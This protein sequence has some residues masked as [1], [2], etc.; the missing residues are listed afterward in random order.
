MNA[1]RRKVLNQI[2]VGLNNS[3]NVIFDIISEEE[4]SFDNM[5]EPMQDGI[6]GEKMQ[7]CICNLED[8]IE[9]LETAVES[10]EEAML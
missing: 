1:K 8:A 2:I 6:S 5:P 3:K 7:D 4:T 9:E 10:L